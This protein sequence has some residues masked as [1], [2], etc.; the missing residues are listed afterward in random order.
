M[1][2]TFRKMDVQ[3]IP[4]TLAVRLSTVEN[5]IT[6]EELEQHYGVTPESLA[7]ALRSDVAGWLCEDRAAV[8]GFAM[9]DRRSGEVLVVAVRPEYECRGIGRELLTRVQDWLFAE[10]HRALWLLANPDPEVRAS[11]FY[12]KL[13]WSPTGERRGDDH[14]LKL[15]RPDRG[16]R[17]SSTSRYGARG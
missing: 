10:G 1:A 14:V 4:A 2:L 7:D 8:V 12:R 9:G 16:A 15:P 3:D 11:G 13:G 17:R 6:L 5:A